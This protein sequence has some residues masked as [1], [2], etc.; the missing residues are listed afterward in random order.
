MDLNQKFHALYDRSRRGLRRPMS[1]MQLALEGVPKGS[2]EDFYSD[3]SFW[4]P[5]RMSRSAWVEHAPFAFW[6]VAT[7]RPRTIVELGSHTGYSFLCFCQA[8]KKLGL[9]TKVFAVDTWA[10]D[11]HAGFYADKIYSDLRNYQEPRY[12]EFST[13][14]RAT[15]DDALSHFE[16]GSIDLLHIDGR[17]FYEDV[18]HDFESWRS[19]LSSR[20]VVLFHD[21][22]VRRSNFGVHRLWAELSRDYP[23]FEFF[24]EHGLGVLACGRDVAPP[25]QKL[26]TLP[27]RSKA[28]GAVRATYSRLGGAC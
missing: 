27:A 21:T 23:N 20:A 13:L 22:R 28:A 19:K 4:R 7:H 1:R 17:H 6:L 16:D 9:D 11:E 5:E 25:L 15:F 8:V 12:G 2:S 3:V 26:L 18:K 10:G 24:H 14:I